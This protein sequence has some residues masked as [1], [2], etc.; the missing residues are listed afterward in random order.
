MFREILPTAKTLS[1]L[2]FREC[3]TYCRESRTL[4]SGWPLADIRATS[5]R[6]PLS[7]NHDRS[8]GSQTFPEKTF[9]R[10]RLRGAAPSDVRLPPRAR[11]SAIPALRESISPS[12]AQFITAARHLLDLLGASNIQ[13]EGGIAVFSSP[14]IENFATP[15]RCAPS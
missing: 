3:C 7:P 5:A 13:R 1:A 6:P 11:P 14:G 12:L 4:R 2:L 15:F 10:R 8:S 9:R